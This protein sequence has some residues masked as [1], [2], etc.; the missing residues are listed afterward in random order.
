MRVKKLT[1][2]NRP[3]E[4]IAKVGARFSARVVNN[5]ATIDLYDEIG[6]WGVTAKAFKEK[7]DT[8]SAEEI[9]LNINSPGGSVFDGIAMYNDLVE[10]GAVI[11]VSVRGLAASAASFIA[12]AGDNIE[13]ADHAF[14]MIH[15]AWAFAMGDADEMAKIAKTLSK[16]DA[17]LAGIYANKTGISVKEIREMMAE[18]TWLDSGDAVKRGFADSV[19]SDE[20]AEATARFDVSSFSNAPRALLR[21]LAQKVQPAANSAPAGGTDILQAIDAL[22]TTMR[23]K[24]HG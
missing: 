18:E 19:S 17:Q 10:H 1:I 12:M 9:T 6:P 16:I 20:E 3:A 2:Q 8:I 23:V 13:I 7:L 11:N 14:F 22:A 24:A 21:P 5:V 4:P 15:N